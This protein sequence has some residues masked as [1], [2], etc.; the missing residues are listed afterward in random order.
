MAT[1][2]MKRRM[3]ESSFGR[4]QSRN[5]A[6]LAAHYLKNPIRLLPLQTRIKKQFQV[7]SLSLSLFSW[8]T[9]RATTTIATTTTTTTAA[10]ESLIWVLARCKLAQTWVWRPC[11]KH[12]P[13]QDTIGLGFPT[14][15]PTYEWLTY[16]KDKLSVKK[17]Y[18]SH[19]KSPHVES[20][21]GQ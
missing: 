17:T 8:A 13:F 14:L 12:W 1:R 20:V 19:S 21:M 9:T 5:A 4:S 18:K 16:M 7:I 15:P 10:T 2:F 3:I 6:W 11:G